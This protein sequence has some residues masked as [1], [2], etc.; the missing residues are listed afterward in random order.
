MILPSF[1][2]C[3][4]LSSLSLII[5]M[6][7]SL[8]SLS[9]SIRNLWVR[10]RFHPSALLPL[11]ALSNLRLI[12]IRDPSLLVLKPI[13]PSSMVIPEEL[14]LHP[15]VELLLT[16]LSLLLDT[17]KKMDKNITSLRTPGDPTGVRTDTLE[18][19]FLMDSVSVESSPSPPCLTLTE[20]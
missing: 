15:P 11:D 17:E 20:L 9:A 12:L 16:M 2:P 5:L 10:S 8:D 18:L 1:M 13:N 19:E 6:S 4:I 14:S 3:S 7:L